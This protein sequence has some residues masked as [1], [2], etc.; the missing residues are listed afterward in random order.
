VITQSV[1]SKKQ[2][3]VLASKSGGTISVE[4]AGNKKT[5]GS[6]GLSCLGT[7]APVLMQ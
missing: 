6:N 5:P 1:P 4:F 3:C 7:D 2:V